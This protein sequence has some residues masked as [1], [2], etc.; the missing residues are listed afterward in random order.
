MWRTS[1][2]LTYFVVVPEVKDRENRGK[3]IT[4]MIMVD[5]FF[6]RLKT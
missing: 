1:K 3:A 5:H 4:K 2:G 6:Y